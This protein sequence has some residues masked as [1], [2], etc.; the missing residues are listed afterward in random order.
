M[1]SEYGPGRAPG[2]GKKLL[3]TDVRM[4]NLR[5]F[6]ARRWRRLDRRGAAGV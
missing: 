2:A 4:L 3:Q 1:G 6:F 5:V